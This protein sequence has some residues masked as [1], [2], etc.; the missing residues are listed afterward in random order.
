LVSSSHQNATPAGVGTI[1]GPPSASPS[2][3]RDNAIANSASTYSPSSADNPLLAVDSPSAFLAY[4][5]L[6]VDFSS[7]PL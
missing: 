2:L 6:V 3:V 4:L 7:Y 1:S 5:N